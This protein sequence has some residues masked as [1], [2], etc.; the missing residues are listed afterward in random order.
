MAWVL[1]LS[2]ICLTSYKLGMTDFAFTK[3]FEYQLEKVR[4]SYR[5]DTVFVGDSSLGNGIDAELWEQ[6]SGDKA[7]N[8]ALTGVYGYAGS[9]NMLRRVVQQGRPNRVIIMHTGDMFARNVAWDGWLHTALGIND[10]LE[11][12]VSEI[13]RTF[14]NFDGLTSAA[15]ALV[16]RLGT[17]SSSLIIDDYIAQGAPINVGN[18]EHFKLSIDSFNSDKSIFLNALGAFCNEN[19]LECWYGFGPWYEKYCDEN[20]EWLELVLLKAQEAGLKTLP[21]PYCFSETQI[22]DSWDH[23]AVQYKKLSTKYYFGELKSSIAVDR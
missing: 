12:P 21:R 6:L 11:V 9:L 4:N 23:V 2:S 14:A 1:I 16:R 10:F 18:E 8:L 15:R 5:V 7:V 22:G 17:P 3:L 20:S 19:S 13:L